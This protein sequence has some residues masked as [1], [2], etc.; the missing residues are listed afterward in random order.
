MTS[1][2]HGTEAI[3]DFQ[4]MRLLVDPERRSFVATPVGLDNGPAFHGDTLSG[5]GAFMPPAGNVESV[6][7]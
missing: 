2:N 3:I 6:R 1:P 5:S 4:E 7:R